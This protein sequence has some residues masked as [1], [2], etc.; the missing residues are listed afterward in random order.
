M[1]KFDFFL[2]VLEIGTFVHLISQETRYQVDS[3]AVTE[4]NNKMAM[5]TS[6]TDGK[7]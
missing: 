7:K 3:G 1:N 5:I 4:V 2:V 6:T